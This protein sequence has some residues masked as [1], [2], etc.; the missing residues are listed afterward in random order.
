MLDIANFEK[1]QLLGNILNPVTETL[2]NEPIE[3]GKRYVP[4]SV[5]R[6]ML[7]HEDKS[8]AESIKNLE[9]EL[10]VE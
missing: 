5:K 4:W 1:K 6:Q 3:L 9:K 8:R 7:E 2:N 10:G